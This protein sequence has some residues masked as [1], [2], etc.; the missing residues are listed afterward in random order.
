MHRLGGEAA[1]SIPGTNHSF[2]G[3]LFIGLI[4]SV[5]EAEEAGPLYWRRV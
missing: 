1:L 2:S 3:F 5:I 4:G